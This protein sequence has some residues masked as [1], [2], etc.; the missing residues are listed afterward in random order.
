MAY[1]GCNARLWGIPPRPP[2][3]NPV[4]KFWSWLRDELHRLDF[5][6][7]RAKRPPLTKR[8]FKDRIQQVLRSNRAQRV[9]GNCVVGRRVVDGV[10]GLKKVCQQVVNRGGAASDG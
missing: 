6:D 7:L 5:L 8:E 10:K 1:E 4:E 9:A 2:D 3:L